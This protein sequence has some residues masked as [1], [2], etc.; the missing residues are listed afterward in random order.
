MLKQTLKVS[1]FHRIFTN[2]PPGRTRMVSSCINLQSLIYKEIISII[3]CSLYYNQTCINKLL[4][5]LQSSNTHFPQLDVNQ[6]FSSD[7]CLV[8]CPERD[9]NQEKWVKTTKQSIQEMTSYQG[10]KVKTK[11]TRQEEEGS[12]VEER[13]GQE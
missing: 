11:P 1:D 5:S 6:R 4:N 10:R 7:E 2:F 9:N 12:R 8:H 3:E 13:L